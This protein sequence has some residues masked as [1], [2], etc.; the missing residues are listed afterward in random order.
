MA[1][2][3]IVAAVDGRILHRDAGRAPGPG[4]R[5]VRPGS[6]AILTISGAM[7]L[8]FGIFV[9]SSAWVSPMI[10]VKPHIVAEGTT[11]SNP[12]PPASTLAS[13]ASFEVY[14]VTVTLIPVSFSN[15]SRVRGSCSPPSCRAAVHLRRRCQRRGKQDGCGKCQSFHRC[16]PCPVRWFF[17]CFKM[18]SGAVARSG[19]ARAA[20]HGARQDVGRPPGAR[21]ASGSGT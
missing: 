8:W 10:D 5:L 14:S 11:R 13:A 19:S 4:D 12:W 15:F 21:S 2:V 6:H 18:V 1:E 7:F 20:A 16:L 3:L 9:R 17:V